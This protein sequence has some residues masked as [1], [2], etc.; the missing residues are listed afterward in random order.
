MAWHH[1]TMMSSKHEDRQNL[2][3]KSTQQ[4]RQQISPTNFAGQN[5]GK[6][7]TIST[8]IPN[9]R[10]ITTCRKP[11][12]KSSQL[13]SKTNQQIP[14][15]DQSQPVEN[16]ETKVLNFPAK[17]INNIHQIK[18]RKQ[19]LKLKQKLAHKTDQKLSQ[20]PSISPSKH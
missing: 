7:T 9:K 16:L 1:I 13:S 17:L 12:D 4:F 3:N 6:T 10:S 20:N 2:R 8:T 19:C 18:P 11:W 5:L 14:T 15:K